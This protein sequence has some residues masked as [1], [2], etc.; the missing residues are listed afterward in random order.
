M[1]KAFL[2]RW[3]DWPGDKLL[4]RAIRAELRR[5]GYAAH[6]AKTREVTLVAIERPGWVQVYRFGVDTRDASGNAVTLLGLSRDDGR[7]SKIEI[8]LTTDE[9]AWR[10]RVEL[11]SDGLIRRDR[12]G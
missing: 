10:T 3:R 12:R 9:R 7:K 8:L 2:Q 1:L 6:T 11:W 5:Q 4:D